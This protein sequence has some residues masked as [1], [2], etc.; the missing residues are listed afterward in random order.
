MSSPLL[1]KIVVKDRIF[2]VKVVPVIDEI[3]V[4][5]GICKAAAGDGD[6]R[7]KAGGHRLDRKLSAV[8]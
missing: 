8:K 1:D 6:L 3:V 4:Q 5:G 2:V 7:N